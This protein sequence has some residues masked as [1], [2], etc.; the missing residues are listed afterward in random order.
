MPPAVQETAQEVSEDCKN[1]RVS[2]DQAQ[3]A[4]N[5]AKTA[6]DSAQLN[7]NT[8]CPRPQG[9]P[10]D[11][12]MPMEVK[13]GGRRSRSRSRK[14]KRKGG[15]GATMRGGSALQ[16]ESLEMG[17][18]VPPVASEVVG[19][20][21]ASSLGFSMYGGKRSRSKASKSKASKASKS[22]SKLFPNAF[23][24]RFMK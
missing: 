21:A 15:C 22:R 5:A 9:A 2:V 3:A 23:L 13:E 1:A 7:A 4:L 14:R 16:Y 10:D 18:K 12:G 8:M 24:R 20:S 6:L 17:E 11:A 19:A